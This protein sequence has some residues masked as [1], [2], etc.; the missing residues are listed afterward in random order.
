MKKLI[1]RKIRKRFVPKG[2]GG[3][4]TKNLT[5]E[6]KLYAINHSAYINN[7]GTIRYIYNK[8]YLYDT[9]P[10]AI[11]SEEYP[12]EKSINSAYDSYIKDNPY[13]V[14]AAIDN[15]K[16]PS[17][18]QGLT[19]NEKLKLIQ[20]FRP[21]IDLDK[22]SHYRD[23]DGVYVL[24]SAPLFGDNQFISES[25][26]P[27]YLS[28][29]DRLNYALNYLINSNDWAIPESSI[30]PYWTEY[31]IGNKVTLDTWRPVIDDPSMFIGHSELRT[32]YGR[33]TKHMSDPDYSILYNN[34]SDAT[35]RVLQ[36]LHGEALYPGL[37]TTPGDVRDFALEHGWTSTKR[38]PND[39]NRLTYTMTPLQDA[40]LREY[41]WNAAKNGREDF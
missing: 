14:V 36:A 40:Y 33:V 15:S 39:R 38:R 22:Y 24:T 1:P 4:D 41:I 29:A 2:E 35:R 21:Y 26:I 6:D 28:N 30:D 18:Y 8:D 31:N 20:K 23:V 32:P 3:L 12:L 9:N 10:Y 7:D 5:W 13:R 34:C 27:M 16:L 19:P 37:F 17:Q 11:F 25:E